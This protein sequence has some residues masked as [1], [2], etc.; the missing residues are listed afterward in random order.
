MDLRNQKSA[1]VNMQEAARLIGR[2][3]S[4]IERQAGSEQLDVLPDSLLS[5]A[6]GASKACAVAGLRSGWC[7]SAAAA[8]V[9]SLENSTISPEARIIIPG[10]AKVSDFRRGGYFF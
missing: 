9:S 3:H 2:G 10:L 6:P 7:P 5:V 8:Y 4:Q 1:Y